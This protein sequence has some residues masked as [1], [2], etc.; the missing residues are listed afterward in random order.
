M[1]NPYT[2]DESASEKKLP[3]KTDK[4]YHKTRIWPFTIEDAVN[5]AVNKNTALPAFRQLMNSTA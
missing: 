3:L 4:V 5:I 2:V 1:S